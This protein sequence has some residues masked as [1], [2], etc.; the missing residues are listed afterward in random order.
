MD[1]LV[2]RYL[3]LLDQVAADPRRPIAGYELLGDDERRQLAEFSGSRAP[4]PE[5]WAHEL[6][7]DQA[8][9]TPDAVAVVDASGART[10]FAE[11]DARSDRLARHLATLGVGRGSV[12]GLCL[13]RDARLVVALLAV[14]KAGGAYLPLESDLPAAR[15]AFMA[16]D[17]GA[18][19]VLTTSSAHQAV[20]D[21]PTAVDIDA[22]PSD[23]VSG[24]LGLPVVAGGDVAWVLYTS[25]S[26]GRPKGV[27][28]TH[29]G[30]A[31]RIA[32]GARAQ[33]FAGDEVACAKSRLGFVDAVCELFAPLAAGVPVVLVDDAVAAD[34]LALAEL[35]V[36]E[37]VT[38]LV[39]VPSLLRVLSDVAA[40]AL[41]RSRLRLITASGEP[42]TA[43]DV[44]ALR[45]VLPDCELW[46]IYG[47]T[48]VA[49]DATAHRVDRLDGERVP[50]GRPLDNVTIELHDP[51]G[52][53]VAL[54]AIG[55]IVVGGLGVSPGY[56][57][58]ARAEGHRF[59]ADG[60]YRTG[61]LG[62]WRPDG[63]LEH[64]GRADRQL[65]IRGVRVEPDE[66]EHALKRHPHI[67]DAAVTTQPGPDG[68][69]LAAFYTT[70]TPITTDELRAHLTDHLPTNLI[71]THLT[72][73]PHLPH[74]PNGKTDHHTLAR[75]QPAPAGPE[76][77]HEPPRTP[78][79]RAVAETFGE[80]TG[81]DRVGRQDDFFALGGHSLLATRAVSRLGERLGKVIE[82][83]LIFE[84]RTVA[85]F[86]AAVAAL[87][88]AG[89][90]PLPRIRRVD[91]ERFRVG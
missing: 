13:P 69:A 8:A 71:P 12:V 63:T 19:L 16:E 49:A 68:P 40:A 72:E 75:M 22:V 54:G 25:G 6:V 11:L 78:E 79:E 80:L 1:R 41:A 35:V 45:R 4:L 83:R 50:I 87:E 60:R 67:A 55:E 34:P 48:E 84:H 73:L 32:W 44:R 9:R 23:V 53:L 15:L 38:R 7:C 90:A 43:T 88:D 39:A 37:R 89:A 56:L 51:A 46:N 30:L 17:A 91:R 21:G 74:L 70:T 14:L 52:E 86:A 27:T 81:T 36:R 82:L 64:H 33:P 85:D 76:S 20:P 18:K 57:G 26:S 5:R 62:R 65:K 29:V 47:C 28:G 42:L 24:G 10:T 2:Q 58:H 59:T 31:N 3:R 77:A 61:D 66:L